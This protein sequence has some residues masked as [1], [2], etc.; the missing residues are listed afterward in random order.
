MLAT[1]FVYGQVAHFDFVNYDD[2]DYTT[3]NRHIRTGL[4]A[5]NV[6]WAFT[7]TY[8]ANWIPLT[9]ISHMLDFQFFGGNRMLSIS[10]ILSSTS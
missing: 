8:A 5:A 6:A 2:P 7:S 10:Q 1:L 4:S 3:G 9:W